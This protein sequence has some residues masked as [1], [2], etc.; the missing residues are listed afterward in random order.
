MDK[1]R[2]IACMQHVLAKH[3]PDQASEDEYL[4]HTARLAQHIVSARRE[5]A[6]KGGTGEGGGSVEK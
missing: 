5:A 3:L 1:N 6:R 4:L 2:Y